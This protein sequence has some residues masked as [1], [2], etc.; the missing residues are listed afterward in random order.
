MERNTTPLPMRIFLLVSILAFAVT[1]ASAQQ[2]RALLI[3]INEYIP[4]GARSVAPSGRMFDNLEGTATDVEAMR[5]LLTV[6][7]RFAEADVTVLQDAQATR[8]G[9]LGALDDLVSESERGALKTVVFYYSGHGSQVKNEATNEA[10]GMDETLVPSDAYLGAEEIRDKE[11]RRRFNALLENGVELTA[12]YDNCHS[13]SAS[14]G[15][16]S[17]GKS[18]KM[19]PS[20]LTVSDAYEGPEPSSFGSALIVSAASEYQ[21]AREYTTAEGYTGGIFTQTLV[22]VANTASPNLPVR[23]LFQQVVARIKSLGFSQ[24][25]QI[26]AGADRAGA[27]LLGGTGVM[28]NGETVVALEKDSEGGLTIR[29]GVTL[30]IHPGTLLTSYASTGDADTL[31]VNET[32][33]PARASVEVIGGTPD[34]VA[35]GDLFKVT[36]WKTPDAPLKLFLPPALTEDQFAAATRAIQDLKQSGR[37][38]VSGNPVQR[39]PTHVASWTGNHWQLEQPDGSLTPLGETLGVEQLEQIV[40]TQ[41]DVLYVLLPPPQPFDSAIRQRFAALQT[42]AQLVNRVEDAHYFLSALSSGDAFAWYARQ[43]TRP[44]PTGAMPTNPKEVARVFGPERAADTLAGQVLR[45]SVAWGW[46]NLESPPSNAVFPYRMSSLIDSYTDEQIALGDT[47][48]WKR[49]YRVVLTLDQQVL[50]EQ[51]AG[52]T[53]G[54]TP[55]QWFYYVFAIDCTGASGLYLGRRNEARVDMLAQ[56]LPESI[57]LGRSGSLFMSSQSC[58]EQPYEADQFFLLATTDQLPD[59]F[60]LQWKGVGTNSKTRARGSQLGNLLASMSNG[61]RGT[62]G[63]PNPSGW[64]LSKVTVTSGPSR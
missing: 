11:I 14:R 8:A 64:W 49:N 38:E 6:R 58:K 26:E 43:A 27:P 12:I 15:V 62:D 1:P 7:Y 9:I 32:Y 54:S 13:G 39:H 25:P 20:P 47:I 23:A 56:D 55:T 22:D 28:P 37:I 61:Q 18:R 17:V 44:G 46:L 35:S 29:G 34:D 60:I 2:N 51:R 59:P 52:R 53:D 42:P 21:L 63:T 31:F 16:G 19:E 41:G 48:R 5:S 24:D 10:D 40:G 45:M 4:P 50:D 3:G 30:G 36:S 57:V 33:G